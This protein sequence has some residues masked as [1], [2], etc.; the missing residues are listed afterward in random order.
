MGHRSPSEGFPLASCDTPYCPYPSFRKAEKRAS[1]WATA[2]KADKK[3]PD[4]LLP[5]R[6]A[7]GDKMSDKAGYHT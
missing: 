3:L 4:D 7:T 5:S 6:R 1:Q 2:G